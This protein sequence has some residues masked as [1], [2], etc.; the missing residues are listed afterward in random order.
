MNKDKNVLY[1][2]SGIFA[3]F[4]L[5]LCVALS[6][7][8]TKVLIAVFTAVFFLLFST[9]IKKRSILNIERKQVI[10]I[11]VAAALGVISLYFA[12]GIGFGFYKTKP[13]VSLL[14][15]YN[16]PCIIAIIFSENIRKIMLAQQSRFATVI[17][18]INLVIIDILLLSEGEIFK[19]FYF[20]NN[21]FAMAVFPSI[22]SNILYHFIGKRYG[23]TP[24]IIYKA[25]IFNFSNILRVRPIMPES[26]HSFAKILIPILLMFF[27]KALYIKKQKFATKRSKVLEF[28]LA[29]IGIFFM[30][31]FVMLI[32]CQF[33]FGILVVATES[34][35]GSLNKG[36]AIIYE[37]YNDQVIK[38]GQV[39]V[40][41]SNEK[42]TVHRVVDIENINGQTRIY[43]K[44]D[45]NEDVDTG[46]ITTDDVIGLLKLKI[47]Y[48]GYPTVWARE[49]F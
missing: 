24:N 48:L 5:L 43:T 25:L 19:S 9:V 38:T 47:K 33:K 45:A 46:Y 12:T 22:T 32:S 1:I 20:A 10:F 39:L 13:P 17:S 14:W 23:A 3:G 2:L 49:L 8:K 42:N 18:Y 44:G 26:L 6:F 15:E 28:S 31:V 30:T 34:M 27:I 36:D 7:A 21:F 37:E 41:D 29:T 35:T 4:L 16:L 40:F 11:M